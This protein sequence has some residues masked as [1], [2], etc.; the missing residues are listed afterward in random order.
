MFFLFD[1]Y[2]PLV[3]PL[4]IRKRMCQPN[5]GGIKCR[6]RRL[7]A[8]DRRVG[9]IA[10]PFAQVLLKELGRSREEVQAEARDHSPL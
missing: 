1:S 9:R 6:D 10:R 4:Y 7:H 3:L 5:G 2:I 8:Q